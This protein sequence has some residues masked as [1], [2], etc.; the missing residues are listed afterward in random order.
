M[1]VVERV[2]G[3]FFKNVEWKNILIISILNRP[4][5]YVTVNKKISLGNANQDYCENLMC[6]YT[7]HIHNSLVRQFLFSLNFTLSTLR[8]EKGSGKI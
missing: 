6:T 5:V 3:M 8:G 4:T 7:M 2:F 1:N